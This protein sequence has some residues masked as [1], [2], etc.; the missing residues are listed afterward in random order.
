MRIAFDPDK[1][2]MNR[3]KHGLSLADAADFDFSVARI[4]VDE[5]YDYGETRYRAYARI[6]GLGFCL[7][8]TTSG[9][10]LRPISYRRAHN[11]EMRRYE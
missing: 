11:E 9:E 2:A 6:D 5:R 1:D 8:F 3:A 10:V 4:E 7:V